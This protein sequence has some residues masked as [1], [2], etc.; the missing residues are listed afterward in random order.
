MFVLAMLP[1]NLSTAALLK[2][3]DRNQIVLPIRLDA[4]AAEEDQR[5]RARRCAGS[6]VEVSARAWMCCAVPTASKLPGTRPPWKR[7]SFFPRLSTDPRWRRREP[8]PRRPRR[9]LRFRLR[10]PRQSRNRWTTK[11]QPRR[12]RRLRRSRSRRPTPD[13]ARDESIRQLDARI[14]ANPNDVAAIYARGQIYAKNRNFSGAIKDFDEVSGST[15]RMPR[16][17]TIAAG[18]APSPAIFQA[19]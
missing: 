6:T 4:V 9:S 19:H 12:P 14:R 5:G 8:T 17:S 3:I 10:R 1:A 13:A 2:G 7:N 16:R 15:R 18:R 11:S